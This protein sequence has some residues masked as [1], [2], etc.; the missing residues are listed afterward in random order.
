MQY[1]ELSLP[2][3]AWAEQSVDRLASEAVVNGTDGNGGGHSYRDLLARIFSEAQKALKRDGHLIFSYANRDPD[4]WADVLW[5]LQEARLQA[6]GF[7]I[8]HSENETD[9]A[10]RGVRACTL[11]LIMDLVPVGTAVRPWAPTEEEES[12]EHAF[13]SVVGEFFMRV[14]SLQGGLGA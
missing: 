13:L 11:D 9:L 2:F 1:G 14:A 5:A 12:A 10:K 8:L 6:A 3:R 4:A 7:Q